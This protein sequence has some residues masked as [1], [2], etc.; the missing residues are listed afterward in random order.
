MSHNELMNHVR[1]RIGLCRVPMHKVSSRTATNRGAFSVF[2]SYQHLHADLPL[3]F[4]CSLAYSIGF[5]HWNFQSNDNHKLAPASRNP[6]PVSRIGFNN[7]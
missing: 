7:R 4:H 3:G 1:L 2:P 6:R 5:K